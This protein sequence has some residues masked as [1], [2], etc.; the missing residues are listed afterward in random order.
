[1]LSDPVLSRQE[2]SD[3]DEAGPSGAGAP[4]AKAAGKQAKKQADYDDWKLAV[5][6]GRGAGKMMHC[7]A[8][9]AGYQVARRSPC[10]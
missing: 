8:T 1:M 7:G 2:L 6:A 5:L 9:V 3:E 10:N 4:S